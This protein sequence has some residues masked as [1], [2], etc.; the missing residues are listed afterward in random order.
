MDKDGRAYDSSGRYKGRIG[1]DGRMYDS[2]GRYKGQ[3]R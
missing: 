1:K 3:T 2:S